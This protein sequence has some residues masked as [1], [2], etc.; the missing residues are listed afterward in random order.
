MTYAVFQALIMDKFN[1]LYSP[2]V[3]APSF[4][5]SRPLAHYFISSSHNT[6]LSLDQLVGAASIDRYIDVLRKGCRCVEID[7]WDGSNG[8]PVVWHGGTLSN[9]ILF[10]CNI[11]IS[12][13]R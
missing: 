4:D 3:L 7:C 13:A 5:T 2:D 11:C 12:I 9:Q 10:E 6:Y 1:D 8:E